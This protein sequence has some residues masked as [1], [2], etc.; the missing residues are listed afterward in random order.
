MCL[1]E[2]TFI[3]VLH[4]RSDPQYLPVAEVIPDSP[5]TAIP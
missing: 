4:L 1:V 3:R 2:R 5:A